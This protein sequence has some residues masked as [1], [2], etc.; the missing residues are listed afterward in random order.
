MVLSGV[1]LLGL[2]AA[3]AVAEQGPNGGRLFSARTLGPGVIGIAVDAADWAAL[4]SADTAVR[5]DAFP[6]FDGRTVDLVVEPFSVTS[7]RTRFVVGRKGGADIPLDLGAGDVQLLRG[8]VA[9]MAGSHVFMALHEQGSFA[10]VDLGAGVGRYEF[11]SRAGRGREM[12]LAR[13]GGVGSLPPGLPTC[14]LDLRDDLVAVVTREGDT[15]GLDREPGGGDDSG[16]P[17]VAAAE[18]GSAALGR[19]VIELAAETDYE[20][21]ELF[22]NLDAAAAYV[23]EMVGAMSDVYAR[24]VNTS[25][26][27]SFVRLWDTPDDLFNEPDPL[28]AF[29]L[30]WNANMGAVQRDV[31]QFVSG[32]RDLPYGGV[33]WVGSLCGG[34]GYSVVGYVLGFSSQAWQP[35]VWN[36]DVRVAAHE[37][38]HSCAALHTHDYA[39]DNCNNLNGASWRGTIMSYCGQT[40]SGG[41]ANQDVRFHAKV[42]DVMRSFITSSSCI[43]TDCDLNGVHDAVDIAGGAADANG[44][45]VPDVCEDCND[46]GTLDDVDISTS[47]SLDLN[48]N[49]IP[50]ECEPDCNNNNKPDDLDISDQTSDDLYGNRIPDECEQDC[51]SNDVSDYTEILADMTLDVNRNA[52]LDTCEDCDDDGQTDSEALAGA[53]N[54]W[55]A[56]GVLNVI[57]EFHAAS[58]VRVKT[59]AAGHVN[60]GQDLI[61]APDGTILVTSGMDDRVVAFDPA[62]GAYAGDFVTAGSGG[63]DFPTGMTYTPDGTFLLVCSR[64]TNS[65]LGYFS[66]TGGFLA[67]FVPTGSGGLVQPFGLVFGPNGNLFVTSSD[68]QVLE[69]DGSGGGFIGRFVKSEDNGGLDSPRGLLFKPDGNLLVASYLSDSVLE[70]SGATGAFLGKFNHGG[71]EVA[72][73]MDLP[74]GLRLGP[75]GNLFVSRSGAGATSAPGSGPGPGTERLHLNTT[76]IFEFDVAGGNFIRSY[77][78]GNDSLLQVP[79]GLDFAPGSDVDCNVNA[80]PDSCDITAGTS[81]DNDNDGVPDECQPE[82]IPAVSQW[83]MLVMAMLMLVAATLVFGHRRVIAA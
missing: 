31:A 48:G 24:D 42:Q 38:G 15:S 44:N 56:S 25:I 62:T 9:G 71:T 8:R 74:W 5:I 83:G 51:N 23:V 72:L 12:A 39:I 65:V 50:D 29:R 26:E 68:N 67:Q 75:N 43:S 41:N 47:F 61:V 2:C 33:A 4:R 21:F 69:F 78:L 76:R 1:G 81:L 66:S 27:L 49:G 53:H 58:G 70:Y 59:S 11:V 77:V 80:V 63:L 37:L 60:E 17:A 6:L 30:Y 7:V 13:W 14:G 3:A 46:N 35:Y 64:N 82:L 40:R 16:E 73:T 19:R 79:T 45:G 22:G 18:Q 55:V 36:Y 20:F 32:R 34:F 28:S 54:L 57:G 52:I 10:S